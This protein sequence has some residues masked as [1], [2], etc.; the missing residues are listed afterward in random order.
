LRDELLH[1]GEIGLLPAVREDAGA[2]L[3]HEAR[4][5]F[6]DGGTHGV[7]VTEGPGRAK[8]KVRLP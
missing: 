8:R 2:E 3:D 6:E 5:V 4:D 1:L 7:F